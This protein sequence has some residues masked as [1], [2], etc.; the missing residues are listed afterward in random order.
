MRQFTKSTKKS[1]EKIWREVTKKA[2]HRKRDTLTNPSRF[3]MNTAA[4]INHLKLCCSGGGEGGLTHL[5]TIQYYQSMSFS[6]YHYI[7]ASVAK[8]P[9]NVFEG[10]E[11]GL[12]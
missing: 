7:K 9:Y 4:S 6:Q 8:C 11:L 5:L 12:S 1:L 10:F 2:Q 3:I